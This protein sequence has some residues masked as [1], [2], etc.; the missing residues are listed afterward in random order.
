LE[1][2]RLSQ[3]KGATKSLTFGMCSHSPDLHSIENCWGGR[4]LFQSVWSMQDLTAERDYII[5]GDY[6]RHHYIE[7][8]LD[9]HFHIKSLD[10]Y[11]KDFIASYYY[12]QCLTVYLQCTYSVLLCTY[13][14]LLCTYSVLQCTYCV[15]TV[16]LQ[17]LTVYLQCLTV[18]YCVLTVYLQCLTVSY[19]V[20]TV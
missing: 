16:Y 19:C 3:Q 6:I 2:V 18:S 8:Y 11:Q 4:Y 15:L 12:L 5:I 13:S 7:I 17:C 1:I 10:Y 20:L 14:V 9:C